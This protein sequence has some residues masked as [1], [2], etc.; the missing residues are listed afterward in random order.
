MSVGIIFFP[1][2]DN[3]PVGLVFQTFPLLF[4]L[5]SLCPLW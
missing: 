3:I 5:C 2:I 4:S 1:G